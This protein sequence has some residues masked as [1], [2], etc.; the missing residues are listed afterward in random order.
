V[1]WAFELVSNHRMKPP[2]HKRVVEQTTTDFETTPTLAVLRADGL[3]L[4]YAEKVLFAN[5]SARVMPGVTLVC[6]GTGR[7]KSTLLRLLAGALPLNAGQLYINGI[8]LHNEPLAY[9]EQVFWTEPYCDEFDQI[10]AFEYFELQRKALGGFTDGNLALLVDGLSLE[11]HLNKPLYMLSTGSKRK[12][13]MAAAFAS[14]AAV[15]L[16][17]EPFAALDTASTNFILGMLENAA[18]HKTRAW[19]LAHYEAPGTVQLAG[20]IDLGD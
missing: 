12:V 8:S 6:G 16:L 1:P 2:N 4:K 18:T 11:P 13:W 5:F 15:T 20:M 10:T 17:D 19:V 14:N 9:R 7:G 3:H